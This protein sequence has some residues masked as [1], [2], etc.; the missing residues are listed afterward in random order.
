MLTGTENASLKPSVGC[1][2]VVAPNAA[3]GIVGTVG[4]GGVEAAV[5][6]VGVLLDEVVVDGAVEVEAVDEVSLPEPLP[7]SGPPT[8]PLGAL[9][10][11]NSSS[12]LELGSSDRVGRA[13]EPRKPRTAPSVGR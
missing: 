12:R 10:G 2:A 3:A 4:V 7:P 11:I 6:P 9:F 13:G 1:A 5:G 8:L